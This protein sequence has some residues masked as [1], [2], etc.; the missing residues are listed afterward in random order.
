MLTERESQIVEAALRAAVEGP[1][2]P[3]WEFHLLMG[4]ERTQMGAILADWP[5]VKDRELAGLAVNNSLV[6]LL[7]Y[8][9]DEWASFA[10]LRDVR[11][12]EVRQVLDRWREDVGY[13]RV[14]D[15]VRARRDAQS[16]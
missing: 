9:P 8:P 11:V 14:S 1:F 15:L 4:V 6:N 13:P 5:I 7:R 2:F 12:G 3:E 10:E 16:T